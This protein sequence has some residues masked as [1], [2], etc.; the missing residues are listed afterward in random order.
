MP[1]RCATTSLPPAID[2][3]SLGPLAIQLL[4]LLLTV[5]GV[6]SFPWHP[7]RSLGWHR[8]GLAS[9][10]TTSGSQRLKLVHI[11]T[12]ILHTA[13]FTNAIYCAT[14]SHIAKLV[15][16]RPHCLICCFPYFIFNPPPPWP[17]HPPPPPCSH[18][19]CWP[20]RWQRRRWWSTWARSPPRCAWQATHCRAPSPQRRYVF[21]F[22]AFTQ[23]S[24]PPTHNNP[25]PTQ[26]AATTCGSHAVAWSTTAT[27]SSGISIRCSR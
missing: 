14:H 13:I 23:H 25:Q 6:P 12:L 17:P 20:P 4:V 11:A 19:P 3:I 1:T 21:V 15:N 16:Q 2:W 18:P 27:T 7:C 22:I 5:P 24:H 8:G 9:S 26:S 10:A